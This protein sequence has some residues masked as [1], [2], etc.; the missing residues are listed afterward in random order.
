MQNALRKARRLGHL[1]IIERP[2]PGQKHRT[3]LITI[4]S[5]AWRTWI[6]RAP[7]AHRPIGLKFVKM[8]STTKNID[9]RKKEA[10]QENR[11]NSVPI[12]RVYQPD[13]SPSRR[14]GPPR[15]RGADA[16]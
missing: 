15:Y 5:P 4:A 7:S 8:V 13:T 10:S 3:N 14:F 2:V 11:C 1:N 12:N 6:A 9:L 16:V